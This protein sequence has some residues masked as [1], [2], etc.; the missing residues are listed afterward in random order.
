LHGLRDLAEHRVGVVGVGHVVQRADEQ[1]GRS[2]E[3]DAERPSEDP[4]EQADDPAAR[5]AGE[6]VVADLILRLD[7]PVVAAGH[8]GRLDDLDLALGAELPEGS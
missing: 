8:D 4:D 3:E 1:P 5:G 7:V 2:S 6:V